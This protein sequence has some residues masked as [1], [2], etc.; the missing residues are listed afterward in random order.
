MSLMAEWL[1]WASHGHEMYC[2]DPEIMGSKPGQVEP[3]K[4]G[5][6]IHVHEFSTD[7]IP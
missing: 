1:G 2:H 3:I 4:H 7:Q 6:H 5:Q